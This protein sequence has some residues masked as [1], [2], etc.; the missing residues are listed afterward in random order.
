LWLAGPAASM[1][2]GE[3]GADVIKVEDL[4]GG[5]PMRRLLDSGIFPQHNVNYANELANRNKRSIAL[6][7]T[8]PQG[9]EI[10]YRL[11][12]RADVF[13]TN[14][15]PRAIER[16]AMDYERIAALNPR[17]VY[18][19]ITG[20]GPRGPDRDRPAFDEI[21]FWARAGFMSFM[22]EPDTPPVPLHGGIGDLST[23]LSLA[24]G[25]F[26]ALYA[27]EQTGRGQLVDASLFA[28]GL[29]AAGFD[30][31]TALFTGQDVLRSSRQASRSP[32]YNT[33]RCQDG[34]W[35][36]FV[37]PQAERHWGPACRA[38]GI[39]DL[40]RDERYDSEEKRRERSG[41]LVALFDH[42]IGRRPLDEWRRRFDEQELIWGPAATLTEVMADPQVEANHFYSK[43]AHPGLG[44]IREVGLPF[45]LGGTPSDAKSNA[46]EW[47][48]HTKAV[49]LELG[50]SNGEISRLEAAGVIGW[51]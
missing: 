41:E 27:R 5:D 45:Q 39:E 21:A 1:I 36:Q 44:T 13:V 34:R 8:R 9:R 33:Y 30:L 46:P 18:A 47:G 11:V 23:A 26:L 15:R 7:L 3:C 38:L 43:V 4:Q 50:Y 22:G 49:L 51:R 32:L 31:Q 16:L 35:V 37:M 17:L 40:E 42:I 29:W 10:V 48:K 6:D 12:E 24:A 25:V 2:L 19:R 20:Y 14:M 28:S